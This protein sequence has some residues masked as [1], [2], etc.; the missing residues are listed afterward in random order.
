MMVRTNL[1][2]AIADCCKTVRSILI[3]VILGILLPLK[4]SITHYSIP[5]A[6]GEKLVGDSS[7]QSVSICDDL[8][9]LSQFDSL[10]FDRAYASG[11]ILFNGCNRCSIPEEG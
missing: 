3:G 7:V 5:L 2:P 8:L 9:V 11:A 6:S 4:V 10:M 1:M